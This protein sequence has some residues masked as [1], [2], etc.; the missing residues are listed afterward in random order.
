MIESNNYDVL[1]Y[2][3]SPQDMHRLYIYQIINFDK[4]DNM[5]EQYAYNYKYIKQIIDIKT[6]KVGREYAIGRFFDKQF[7]SKALVRDE[8]ITKI[9][10]ITTDQENFESN[11]NL[12]F[13]QDKNN[14]Y[15]FTINK[16]YDENGDINQVYILGQNNQDYYT[17]AQAPSLQAYNIL[18]LIPIAQLLADNKTQ[19]KFLYEQDT[20]DVDLKLDWGHGGIE[21]ETEN[22]FLLESLQMSVW[23]DDGKTYMLDL[24]ITTEGATF[25]NN[26]LTIFSFIGNAFVFNQKVTIESESGKIF[27]YI[28]TNVSDALEWDDIAR[29][30]D[31]KWDYMNNEWAVDTYDRTQY[32]CCGEFDCEDEKDADEGKDQHHDIVGWLLKPIS[33]YARNK[34][35]SKDGYSLV[36]MM[37]I[38]SQV[39]ALYGNNASLEYN[40]EYGND[41][42]SN[43]A[44][45]GVRLASD[46][47][48][49]LSSDDNV[50]RQLKRY[51]ES[52]PTCFN[53]IADYGGKNGIKTNDDAQSIQC[54]TTL[55]FE[56]RDAS[57]KDPNDLPARVHY[58]WRWSWMHTL[59][60]GT[61]HDFGA[62]H[63][64]LH[65]SFRDNPYLIGFDDLKKW[66]TFPNLTYFN[67]KSI[68]FKEISH[69]IRQQDK[70]IKFNKQF[71]RDAWLDPANWEWHF[72]AL[73]PQS[74]HTQWL[75]FRGE[76][77]DNLLTKEKLLN[78]FNTDWT[79]HGTKTNKSFHVINKNPLPDGVKIRGIRKLIVNGIFSDWIKI[80]IADK[81]LGADGQPKYYV[82]QNDLLNKYDESLWTTTI[83]F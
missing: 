64:K 48:T 73:L 42:A 61:V 50:K 11:S 76:N 40:N 53:Q 27:T 34:D 39:K 43:V 1:S 28:D 56:F 31:G 19:L 72:Y 30:A 26:N 51:C 52:L 80:T 16:P 54:V 3:K 13:L 23:G 69:R 46:L 79:K 37:Q 74:R 35:L 6:Y 20:S 45:N 5:I 47:I 65:Y 68:S 67:G 12:K 18:Q 59:F 55:N 38:M 36:A 78:F 77:P 83:N 49:Y 66:V 4:F 9:Q 14:F 33:Q 15:I 63:I 41:D 70:Q 82:F 29:N 75:I 44:G 57:S 58:W 60:G 2:F 24:V 25:Y 21:I 17:S 62:Y 71:D 10:L 7:Q 22:S 32:T 8:D 81:K